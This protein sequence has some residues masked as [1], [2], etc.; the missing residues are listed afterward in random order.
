[1]HSFIKLFV[2]VILLN[3]IRYLAG[4]PFESWLIFNGLFGAMSQ[5]PSVF[6]THYTTFD[7][8]TSYFYNFM[9]WLTVVWLFRLL[10]SNLS[11]SMILKAC[12]FLD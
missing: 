9:M 4:Y 7:W 6:K 10:H 12:K 5:N 3:I 1:M 11:G 8:A 2:L